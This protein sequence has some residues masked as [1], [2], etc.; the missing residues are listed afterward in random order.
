MYDQLNDT[1]LNTS[2]QLV[3][4]ITLLQCWIYEHF[5]SVAECNANPDYDEVSLRACRW[6]VTKKT[7]KKVSTATYRQ[8]LDRLRIPDVYWMPYVEH[9][10]VQDFHP[11]SCFSGQLR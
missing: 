5:P 3:G 7:V 4:Y 8:Q 9:R 10:L 1:S 11:I 6:I 2:R